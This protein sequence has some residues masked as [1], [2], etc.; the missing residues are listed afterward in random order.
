MAVNNLYIPDASVIMKWF[1]EEKDGQHALKLKEDFVN[2]TI[3]LRIPMHMPIELGNILGIKFP[4]HA[5]EFFAQFLTMELCHCAIS[6][7]ESAIT[8]H[9]MH[10]YKGISF[11][12][13][14]YHA[15]AL[16]SKGTFITA[17]EKYYTRT[18]KEGGVMLLNDYH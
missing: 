16:Q 10:T 9:L 1:V 4:N 7:E 15:L 17:D 18:R 2:E 12:D 5:S 8:F 13:A 11:Y 14:A 6:L 3:E